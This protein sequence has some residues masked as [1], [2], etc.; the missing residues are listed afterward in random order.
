MFF[1]FWFV[2]LYVCLLVCLFSFLF[3]VCLGFNVTRENFSITYE[4]MAKHF[5][6]YSAVMEIDH[7]Q[8]R[9]FYVPY[10]LWHRA[11]PLWWSSAT[12]RDTHTSWRAF[13][14]GAVTTCCKDKNLSRPGI[15]PQIFVREANALPL[16]HRGGEYVIH[17]YQI[18]PLVL[19]R[20]G[21]I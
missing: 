10:L 20:S 21:Q 5:N 13:G 11:N 8:C 7:E 12:T 1:V 18:W 14:S 6:L 17:G 15:E 3:F 16:N 19:L 2:C 9:Y 4:W